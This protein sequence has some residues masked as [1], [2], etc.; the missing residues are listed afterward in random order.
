MMA[1]TRASKFAPIFLVTAFALAAPANPTHAQKQGGSITVG[2][3]LDIP[4]FDPLKV[5]VFDTSAE[6][7]A[8]AIFD[9]LTYLDD[10]G[11]PK[12]KLALSWTHSEDYKSWTFKLRPGVK[13]H[14]GTPFNAQAVKEN[15]DRQKDPANKCRCAFYIAFIHDVQAPD[16]LTVVYNLNDPSVNLPAIITVQGVNFTIQSP[17]AWK[18]KGDDYNRNGA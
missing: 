8:A 1:L 9:T 5:G 16:E 6:I 11:E 7:A 3:E 17:T 14:D 18:T 13:F 10:K 4:G 12:P 15:F 2:L